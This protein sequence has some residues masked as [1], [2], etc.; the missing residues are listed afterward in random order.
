VSATLDSI[1][2]DLHAI[3]VHLGLAIADS[4]LDGKYG[5]PI[6]RFDPK[7]WFGDTC[8]G[9]KFSEC[10]PD[11]LDL[12]ASAYDYFAKK[13]DETKA[14][15]D[16]GRPKS[17]WDRKSALLARGWAARHRRNGITPTSPA[18]FDASDAMPS[19]F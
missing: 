18:A 5:D 12:L 19:D 2:A 15:D 14:V 3:K 17:T 6:S 8:K 4:E 16:K 9:A 11:Y 7:G 13:N 1:A 10:P